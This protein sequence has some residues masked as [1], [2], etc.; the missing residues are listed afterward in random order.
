MEWL[1]TRNQRYESYSAARRLLRSD[2][3][4]LHRSIQEVVISY[5]DKVDPRV[6]AR[7]RAWHVAYHA[8][9]D[10]GQACGSSRPHSAPVRRER[11]AVEQLVDVQRNAAL[12][13]AR[14]D[15][16]LAE[17]ANCSAQ[18]NAQT[19]RDAEV[20]YRGHAW[21][22]YLVEPARPAHGAPGSSL[23]YLTDTDSRRE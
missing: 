12:A 2:L 5:L 16:L 23:T 8:C 14:Q 7:A 4:S 10:D 13:Y 6:A 19:V 17:D 20:Y 21:T 15:G 18:Q 1:R 22:R 11:E 9:A 3:Y